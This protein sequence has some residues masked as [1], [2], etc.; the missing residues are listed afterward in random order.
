MLPLMSNYI[1]EQNHLNFTV[2]STKIFTIYFNSTTSFFKYQERMARTKQ[3]PR[4][5]SGVPR[6]ETQGKPIAPDSKKVISQL[7]TGPTQAVWMGMNRGSPPKKSLFK[8]V[9]KQTLASKVAKK[10]RPSDRIKN[11]SPTGDKTARF[12]PGSV[13]LREIR[14]YQKSTELLLRKLP[15][16]RLVREI[17]HKIKG[18]GYRVQA[19]ALEAF[20]ESTEA[21][22]IDLFEDTQLC[23]IHAKRVTI[24]VR[25]MQ[26]ARR[27]RGERF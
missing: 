6:Y 18:D 20:Q 22:I 26:L 15:F 3:V 21:Y 16:Q 12:R 9:P 8:K 13:A 2:V 24:M 23:A 14:R 11:D 7:Q 25:D 19:S 17:V 1:K 4:K 27:L 10:A 5:S